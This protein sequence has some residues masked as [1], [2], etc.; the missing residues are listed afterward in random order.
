MNI[1]P[2]V[3]KWFFGDVLLPETLR[4]SRSFS[5]GRFF[6]NFQWTLSCSCT[7]LSSSE[8]SSATCYLSLDACNTRMHVFN[9]QQFHPH[10]EGEKNEMLVLGIIV[11]RTGERRRYFPLWSIW[12]YPM[13]R[14]EVLSLSVLDTVEGNCSCLWLA[15]AWCY[16][17]EQV[18]MQIYRIRGNSQNTG[19]AAF[20]SWIKAA[21]WR[22]SFFSEQMHDFFSQ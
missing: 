13:E 22:F 12:L 18:A 2:C 17:S 20:D 7:I 11:V 16:S 10:Y 8:D 4:K 15:D 3:S 5:I 9:N 14:H 21:V 19:Y 6:C 1:Y